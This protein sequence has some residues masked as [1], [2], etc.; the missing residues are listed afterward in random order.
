LDFVSIPCQYIFYQNICLVSL[1]SE[2]LS[3]IWSGKQS[4]PLAYIICENSFLLTFHIK[5]CELANESHFFPNVSPLLD[6]LHKKFLD[7]YYSFE[8]SLF[9]NHYNKMDRDTNLNR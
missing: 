7:D 5:Q 4:F 6:K 8:L 2:I 3:M 1:L 9:C